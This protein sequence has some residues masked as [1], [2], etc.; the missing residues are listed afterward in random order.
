MAKRQS[1]RI[2]QERL[3]SVVNVS[4]VPLETIERKIYLIRNRK[5]LLDQDLAELYDVKPKALIQAVKRNLDRFPDDF[6]FQLTSDE[7]AAMRSQSVTASKRNIRYLPYAF[8]QEGVAMLSGVLR[9][10]RAVQANIAIMRTFVRLHEFLGTYKDVADK[11]ENM[12][13]RYDSQFKVV[14]DAIHQLM[15]Q[16]SVPP[17]RRIGFKS[18]D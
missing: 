12:G 2:Q 13:K 4:V 11:L 18:E 3:K 15:K 7:A 9:S 14:F 17:R 16:A 10:K 8:T 5:V 6:M 1:N